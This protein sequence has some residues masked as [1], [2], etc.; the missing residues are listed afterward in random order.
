[1]SKNTLSSGSI[2]RVYKFYGLRKES[3]QGRRGA[4][5]PY[6]GGKDWLPGK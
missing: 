5:S 4:A 3:V 6:E 1:M 2:R